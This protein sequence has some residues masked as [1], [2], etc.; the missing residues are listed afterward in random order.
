MEVYNRFNEKEF[1]RVMPFYRRYQQNLGL[2]F[3]RR[4]VEH[5]IGEGRV[6][7]TPEQPPYTSMEVK[8]H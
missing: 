6:A 3:E 2:R 5:C 8:H 7:I 4:N 1:L